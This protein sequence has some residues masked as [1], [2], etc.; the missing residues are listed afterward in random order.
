MLS[1][2]QLT[3]SAIVCPDGVTRLPGA[4]DHVSEDTLGHSHVHRAA[5]QHLLPAAEVGSALGRAAALVVL[6]FK[7][8]P[9]HCPPT[10]AAVDI[11]FSQ[12]SAS[13]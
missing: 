13:L 2:G 3:L 8:L 1:P 9:A 5:G 7:A 11:N 6:H 12:I 4:Q 10:I